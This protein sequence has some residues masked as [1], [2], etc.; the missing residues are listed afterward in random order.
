MAANEVLTLSSLIK[1]DLNEAY[2]LP[3]WPSTYSSKDYRFLNDKKYRVFDYPP[4]SQTF[5]EYQFPMRNLA[6]AGSEVP[7][8][9]DT[10]PDKNLTAHWKKWLP[11]F[12]PATIKTIEE[13]LSDNVPVVTTGAMQGMSENKHSVNPDT[14]YRLQLKSTIPEINVCS[15]PRINVSSLSFPCLMK[16][17]QSWS[18]R[19]TQIANDLEH[20][21][22]ILSEV[23]DKAEWKEGFVLQECL[24]AI[25]DVPS[26]QFYVS[27]SG[28][29]T[30][31]GTT[32]GGFTGFQWSSAIVEWE[33]QDR[34][35][36][37]VYDDFVIPVKD[38]LHENGYFG[39]VTIEVIFTEDGGRYLCDLNPR[40]GGD[41]THLLLAPYMAQ[42]G[43]TK[44]SLSLMKKFN[45]SSEEL[46]AKANDINNTGSINGNTDSGRV[47]VLSVADVVEGCQADVTVFAKSKSEMQMLFD[48]L[49]SL[50]NKAAPNS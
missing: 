29:V 11:A 17:D 49:N 34:L 21:Q 1:K 14:H 10:Q 20:L 5:L 19:G 44:S 15:P 8:L 25:V 26:Y 23:I 32:V 45:C 18:G 16:I 22:A 37:M 40:V 12:A 38:Y 46:I 7:I 2:F 50:K 41:T 48:E 42:F 4:P 47:I 31:V 13:G 6:T 35:K 30:W 28:E 9:M 27:K 3:A 24:S 43:F 36:D 39:L 33:D